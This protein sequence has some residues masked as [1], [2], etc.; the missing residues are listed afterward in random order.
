[1]QHDQKFAL[2]LSGPF[3]L[4]TPNGRELRISSKKGRALIA[5]LA[6]SSRGARSRGWLQDTLWSRCQRVEAQTNLRRELANL[7]KCLAP[8]ASE[9]ISCEGDRVRLNLQ[10]C[11]IDV[12]NWG[13]ERANSCEEF[14]EGID[15]NGEEPFED[16]LRI[17][18]TSLRAETTPYP[19]N[20]GAKSAEKRWPIAVVSPKEPR[21]SPAGNKLPALG[22]DQVDPLENLERKDPEFEHCSRE[23]PPAPPD[24]I[25]ST[26]LPIKRFSGA[27]LFRVTSP[28]KSDSTLE[29]IFLESVA[30]S[31]LHR[32]DVLIIDGACLDSSLS[33]DNAEIPCGIIL[34]LSIVVVH[35]KIHLS[36]TVEDADTGRLYWT[37]G[38]TV[39][40]QPIIA[41]PS[42]IALA[43]QTVEAAVSALAIRAASGK[44]VSTWGLFNS[45]RMLT[46]MLDKEK[47]IQ[48]DQQCALAFNIDPRGCYLAWRALIRII[49]VFQHRTDAFLPDKQDPVTLSA[50]ALGQSPNIGTISQRLDG[51]IGLL[52]G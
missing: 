41:S 4:L 48:A 14:L 30:T 31:L 49:A 37:S 36:A 5:L 28:I 13:A 8:Y 34:S 11:T 51:V 44:G 2:E 42:F 40:R 52:T 33:T 47:L 9:L 12:V 3:Q 19:E 25:T 27:V 26:P 23:W 43:S 20:N 21:E 17:Q 35:E 1:M 46:S 6:M 29:R 39:E 10:R 24:S 50:E 32:A 22:N 45:V 15:L 18:R 38:F 7:R 16:W